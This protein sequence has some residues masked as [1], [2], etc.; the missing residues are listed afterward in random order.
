VGGWVD[1]DM[2]KNIIPILFIIGLVWGQ[3]YEDVVILK[4]GSEIHGIII[5]QKP[6]DYIKIQSGKNTFVYR[7]DEIEIMKK[8]IIGDNTDISEKNHSIGFGFLTNKTYNLLQYTY[9]IKLNDNFSIY[10]LLGIGNLYGLGIAWQKNYNENGLMIGWSGGIDVGDD[11]F[12]SFSVSY[13]WRIGESQ[14]FFSLGTSNFLFPIISLDR[15][16]GN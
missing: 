9:D 6:N 12:G 7:F 15:R 13:Q 10:G 3:T 11:P 14:N 8:Q 1:L 5:E 2:I 16:F 4:N